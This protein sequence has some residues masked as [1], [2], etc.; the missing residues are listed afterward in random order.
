MRRIV[1]IFPFLLV[2]CVTGSA[3]AASGNAELLTPQVLADAPPAVA[4]FHPN[5]ARSLQLLDQL[6]L[7][8]SGELLAVCVGAG[9]TA[10]ATVR[11]AR[12][13]DWPFQLAYDPTG[14][15][16]LD[17]LGMRAAGSVVSR[18]V[19]PE[20]VALERG[21]AAATGLPVSN[22][23]SSPLAQARQG[24]AA[25]AGA[26]T[27]SPRSFGNSL[28]TRHSL[29]APSVRD[30]LFISV[31][32][33]L[34][35]LGGAALVFGARRRRHADRDDETGRSDQSRAAEEHI[36]DYIRAKHGRKRT[37]RGS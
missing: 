4:L 30:A 27:P 23:I 6:A 21:L 8:S 19:Q 34:V 7:R 1:T 2:F 37:T 31:P 15:V 22:S 14:D 13:R 10:D 18:E 33:M 17:E 20:P 29:E 5:N 9:C 24:T 25:A 28:S 12:Q 35:G 11:V 32:L 36:E 26:L 3:L 16:S